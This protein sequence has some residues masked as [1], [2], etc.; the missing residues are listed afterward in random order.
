NESY[1]AVTYVKIGS[2]TS[3]LLIRVEADDRSRETKASP[4][5]I[6]GDDLLY[7]GIGS[8]LSGLKRAAYNES[9]ATNQMG[10][11]DYV[12]VVDRDVRE[13]PGRWF[14]Y[15]TI[16]LALLCT[17]R[18]DF[19]TDLLNEREHRKEALA[20]WVRRGGRLVISCGHNQDMLNELLS[21]FQFD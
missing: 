11:R 9:Q 15:D 2:I 14:G 5:A 16:D 10:P 4:N 17:T 13:L 21:R 3:E 12:G 18:R 8:R 1:T 7:L 19:V 20:E 6:G